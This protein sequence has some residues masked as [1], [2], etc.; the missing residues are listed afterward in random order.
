[1]D[2]IAAEISPSGQG[3]ISVI[4]LSGEKSFEIVNRLTKK[5]NNNP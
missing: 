5:N 1:M 3:A 2:T 4:R